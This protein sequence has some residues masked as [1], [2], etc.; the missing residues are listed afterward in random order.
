MT[1]LSS[2]GGGSS[3]AALGGGA[4]AAAALGGA[5]DPPFPVPPPPPPAAPPLAACPFIGLWITP[6]WIFRVTASRCSWIWEQYMKNRSYLD[7]MI[8]TRTCN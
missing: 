5:D 8:C 4:L 2:A 6:V 3:T 1:G 7:T